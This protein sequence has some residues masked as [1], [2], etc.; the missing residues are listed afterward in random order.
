M[1]KIEELSKQLSET[2]DKIDAILDAAK[3]DERDLTEEESKQVETL[4]KEADDIQAKLDKAKADEARVLRQAARRSSIVMPQS[5]NLGGCVHLGIPQLD[6]PASVMRARTPAGFLSNEDAYVAGQWCLGMLLGN[7]ESLGWLDRNG[8][9]GLTQVA[10]S[11]TLGGYLVPEQ[12]NTAI[13]DLR[14]KYGLFRQNADVAPMGSDTATWPKWLSGLTTYWVGEE[15]DITGSNMTFGQI[16][17]TARKLAAL[18]KISNDLAEDAVVDLAARVANEVAYAF[19]VKEDSCGFLGDGTSTYGGIVGLIKACAT[20]TA[21]VSTAAAGNTAFSTLDLADFEAMIGKLPEYEGIRPEWYISKAGWAASMM[22][23]ADAAGGITAAEIEGKR[24]LTFLGYPVNL[25]QTMN[26]TLTA[27]TSTNGL[28]YFG[29]LRMAATLGDRRGIRMES[30]KDRYFEYDQLAVKGTERFDIN[31]H[32][33]GDTSSA[34]A[35]IML[36]TPAS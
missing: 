18:C 17:L 12:F 6:I 7:R 19:A 14:Q 26:S 21:T 34:G 27:Q 10:H 2:A 36:A 5:Q 4:E 29:D 22:R 20:A 15:T 16:S 9:E 24:Q 11:N 30:S 35:M 32:S 8:F 25:V 28:C 3:K 31:V 23:L 1:H 33:V 13:I